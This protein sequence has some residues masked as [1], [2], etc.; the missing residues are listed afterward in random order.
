MADGKVRAGGRV[1]VGIIT[2]KKEALNVPLY[3]LG[4]TCTHRCSLRTKYL[5][6]YRT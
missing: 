5:L 3:K 2:M 4:K 1:L 6:N